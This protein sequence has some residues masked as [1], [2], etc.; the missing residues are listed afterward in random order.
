MLL[1]GEALSEPMTMHGELIRGYLEPHGPGCWGIIYTAGVR[2]RREY[3]ERIRWRI[4][5]DAPAHF[6]PLNCLL[7]TSPSPRD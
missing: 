7:Y 2:V 5:Q 4:K 6:N 3:M 1:L